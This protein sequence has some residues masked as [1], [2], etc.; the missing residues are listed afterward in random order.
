MNRLARAARDALRS[1]RFVS[2]WTFLVAGLLSVTV[3]SP[4]PTSVD[5]AA[6]GATSASTA[7]F[8]AGLVATAL[9]ERRVPRR[10]RPWIVTAGVLASALLRPLAYDAVADVLGASAPAAWQL[11]FR[12]LT[13]ATVWMASLTAI[14]I[15]T[16]HVTR[17]RQTNARLLSVQHALTHAREDADAFES[18]ARNL[19][20]AASHELRDELR[21]LAAERPDTASLRAFSDDSVR[22]WSRRLADLA[23][24]PAE[25]VVAVPIERVRMRPALRLPP[26]GIVAVIYALCVLPYAL[27]AVP[28][29]QVLVGVAVLAAGAVLADGVT[30]LRALRRRRIPAFLAI[31]A[32]VG[33]GLGTLAWAQGIPLALAVVPV[34]AYPAFATACALCAGTASALR[35]EERRLTSTVRVA[36]RIGRVGT[37]A[38][39]AALED[40]A[41]E[42]H[43]DAQGACVRALAAPDHWTPTTLRDVRDELDPLLAGLPSV[44]DRPR[45]G[46]SVQSLVDLVETWRPVVDVRMRMSRDARR[47]LEA[48]ATA[49][50]DVFEI[51][52]EGLLNAVKH[53]VPAAAAIDLD[54]VATGAGPRLR[55]QVRSPGG[56][57]RGATLRGSS[58]ARG[59]GA[60]L[61][62]DGSGA[63]LEAVI[64]LGAASPV[65]STEHPPH[66]QTSAS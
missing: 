50:D 29:L 9:G 23:A 4:A 66:A 61:R 15:L 60:R 56:L 48:S 1:G 27:R 34:L 57:P 16:T 20:Q 42:L 17:L 55:V 36:Q 30:R 52:A 31:G 14:A 46:A 7:A 59:R 45:D 19:V 51:V 43:R 44:F 25:P 41:R 28:A 3:M 10:W 62:A 13:N 21:P 47:A 37:S 24:T 40:A 35:V 22:R 58:A 64:D 65:V 18:A 12:V 8:L 63:L 49:R 32:V 38:A 26:P 39:R 2:R 53:S 11:P 6:L 54:V 33:L 5:I